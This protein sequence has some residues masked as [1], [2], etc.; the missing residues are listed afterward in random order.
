MVIFESQGLQLLKFHIF[1]EHD[2]VR[3]FVSTRVGGVSSGNYEALNLSHYSGDDASNVT[4]NRQILA[5]SLQ[6]PLENLMFARQAH[7]DNI[8]LIDNDFLD[9]SPENKS[10]KL[11]NKDAMITN[12]KNIFLNVLSADCTP[13]LLFDPEHSVIAAIHSGYKGCLQQIVGKTIN[14]MKDVFQSDTSEILAAIGPCIGPEVYEIGDDVASQFTNT[15]GELANEWLH[16]QDNGKYL[17]DLW[18][19]HYE[20]L[21]EAGLELHN[22]ELAG[23]CTHEYN[24]MF[25]SARKQGIDSGRF[26]C[27][28]ALLD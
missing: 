7:T 21:L 13:I 15:F 17:L 8:L 1:N 25:F 2:K 6:V 14:R 10:Q 3:Q 4:K 16:P 18:A 12:C 28:I 22:V 19:A 27:G 26:A 23:V 24:D 5:D 9:L 20:Q 11:D